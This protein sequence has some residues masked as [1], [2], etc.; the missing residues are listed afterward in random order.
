MENLDYRMAFCHILDYPKGSPEF[1][2]AMS[3]LRSLI[4]DQQRKIEE[5]KANDVEGWRNAYCDKHKHAVALEVELQ[6]IKSDLPI[7]KR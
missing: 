5:L 4:Q 2:E 7:Q 1:S 3:F 6:Q